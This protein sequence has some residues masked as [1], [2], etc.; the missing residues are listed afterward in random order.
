MDVKRL[1]GKGPRKGSSPIAPT[2]AGRGKE[3][4]WWGRLPGLATMAPG[5]SAEG[6]QTGVSTAVGAQRR[7][8]PVP[9]GHPPCRQ[10]DQGS[11][12]P[13]RT[14]SPCGDQPAVGEVVLAPGPRQ[15]AHGRHLTD[16]G[17]DVDEPRPRPAQGA[18]VAHRVA[19]GGDG[20][21]GVVE[22]RQAVEPVHPGGPPVGRARRPR[23]TRAGAP[24]ESGPGR[25]K[26]PGL[27]DHNIINAVDEPPAAPSMIMQEG[28]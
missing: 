4:G 14:S 5:W 7:T 3:D 22:A 25:S 15:D 24:G 17:R 26:G 6:P 18:A 20:P 27:R 28:C 16:L 23:G 2:S 9:A 13:S 10:G 19:P 11:T 12:A 8:D 1:T 21:I